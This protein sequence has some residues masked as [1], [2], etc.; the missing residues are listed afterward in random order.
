M[1]IRT[2]M[3]RLREM[4]RDVITVDSIEGL[5]EF[6]LRRAPGDGNCMWH[7]IALSENHG[8][9]RYVNLF[10]VHHRRVRHLRK[11]TVDELITDDGDFKDQ[12]M[13]F[14]AGGDNMAGT[15]DSKT[16]LKRLASGNVFGGHMELVAMSKILK[17]E[18]F[19]LDITDAIRI[20]RYKPDEIQNSCMLLVR[21]RCHFDAL[22]TRIQSLHCD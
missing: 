20:Y 6:V 10:N 5:C 7:A 14:W 18:I 4:E 22:V 2:A 16:Y 1:R 13:P 19:V 21:Y 11:L 9:G 15:N 8:Y 17:R 12:Y 3:R